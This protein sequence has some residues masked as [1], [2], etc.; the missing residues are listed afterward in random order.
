MA[1]TA[2]IRT[3]T[4]RSDLSRQRI[5]DAALREFSAEG[6]AGARTD[7]IAAVAGV[8]KALIYYY[9][10]SKENLYNATLEMIAARIRDIS[11]A[12]FLKP[13]SAGERILRFG[14]SHFDR[15]LSQREFQ[16]LMQ[17]EMIRVHKGE[18]SGATLFAQRVFSPM[19]AMFQ[20]LVREGIS[21]GELIDVDWFQF[22]LTVLGANVFYFL[23]APVWGAVMPFDPFAPE[24]IAERRCALVRFLG[25][26]LFVD[27]RH[28]EELAE[29]ILADTPMPE[30][31]QDRFQRRF[32]QGRKNERT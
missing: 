32:L 11:L 13:A 23:A 5:L 6:L 10:E 31:A 2:P 21:S 25:Q 27:R 30:I 12:V 18:S 3:Q 9:F 22:P 4:D 8:N 29:Q 1:A 15:I 28:G 17:Q 26:A 14:L 20:S 19:H 16:S 7:R 24:V